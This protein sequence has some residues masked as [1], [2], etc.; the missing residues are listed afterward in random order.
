MAAPVRRFLVEGIVHAAAWL[1]V[2][3]GLDCIHGGRWRRL[4]VAS[5]LK[6]LFLQLRLSGLLRGKPQ[7]R[8]SRI[9]RWWRAAPLYLLGS[10]SLEQTMVDGGAEVEWCSSTTLTLMILGGMEPDELHARTKAGHTAS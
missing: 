2:K 3:T 8:V 1:P 9:G 5:L 4:F 6:A 10:S 7:T